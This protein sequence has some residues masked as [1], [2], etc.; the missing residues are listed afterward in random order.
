MGDIADDM[1]NGDMD[2]ETGEWIGNGQ[3]FPRIVREARRMENEN[4]RIENKRIDYAK[5]KLK[6][7][8]IVITN[9]TDNM[10]EFIYNGENIKFYPYTGWHTGK[11][12]KDGRGIKNLLSQLDQK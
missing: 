7:L 9:E 12:I 6:K 11:S 2:Y 3:G 4:K 10:L 1:I 8:G 5:K